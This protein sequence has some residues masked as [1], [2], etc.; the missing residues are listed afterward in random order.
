MAVLTKRPKSSQIFSGES[1]T[2]RCTIQRG[3]VTDWEY[4]WSKDGVDLPSRKHKY[5]IS[6]DNISNSVD[7][8]CQGTHIGNG[9]YSRWS[10]AVRLIVTGK[11]SDLSFTS[12]PPCQ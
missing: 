1:V 4:T 12:V 7:Y 2:L 9:T 11:S 6:G 8:R 10:D 3:K 5:E